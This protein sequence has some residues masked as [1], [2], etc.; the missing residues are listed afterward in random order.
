MRLTKTG[1][2]HKVGHQDHFL[3][4]GH[5]SLSMVTL[6][7]SHAH[8]QAMAKLSSEL[9]C[10]CHRRIGACKCQCQKS[11]VYYI[12]M[13]YRHIFGVLCCALLICIVGLNLQAEGTRGCDT[14][15]VAEYVGGNCPRNHRCRQSPS[16]Y[17]GYALLKRA[18]FPFYWIT[19]IIF[20]SRFDRPRICI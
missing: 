7:T 10:M 18:N 3:S 17:I 1:A 2:S 13:Y 5:A 9:A 16:I 12:P 20:V 6:Y 8:N 11:P 15:R 4:C 19:H 14:R